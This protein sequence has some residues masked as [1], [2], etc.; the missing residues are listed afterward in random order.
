MPCP[1]SWTVSEEEDLVER[2][3]CACDGVTDDEMM[4]IVGCKL[5]GVDPPSKQGTSVKS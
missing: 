3:A 4:G 1:L 5:Y 2:S